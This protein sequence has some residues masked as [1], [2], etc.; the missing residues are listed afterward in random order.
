MAFAEISDRGY[1]NTFFENPWTRYYTGLLAGEYTLVD[2][3]MVPMEIALERQ[4]AQE[5]KMRLLEHTVWRQRHTMPSGDGR[6]TILLPGLN[7]TKEDMDS[8]QQ[9][10]TDRG[11][12]VQFPSEPTVTHS[13]EQDIK[14][15]ICTI[16]QSVNHTGRTTV[17]GHSKGGFIATLAAAE[18][19]QKNTRYLNSIDIITLGT[20][21]TD[22]YH[23]LQP[24]MRAYVRG[25]LSN[26]DIRKMASR[27]RT[28]PDAVLERITRIYTP[29][30]AVVNPRDCIDFSHLSRTKEVRGSHSGLIHNPDAYVIINHH[31]QETAL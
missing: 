21:V 6:T 30:D 7:K 17:I 24:W 10:L 19:A 8:L 4:R 22:P 1:T 16:T 11:F 14:E 9:W 5:E 15:A 2:A 27:L 29:D 26:H 31:L 18:L 13:I 20:P 25:F 23:G 3:A 12:T 28:V